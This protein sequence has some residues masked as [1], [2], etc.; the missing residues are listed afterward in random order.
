[1]LPSFGRFLPRLAAV[2]LWGC[3]G[4]FNRRASAT[5][6]RK[7]SQEIEGRRAKE[8]FSSGRALQSVP[9]SIRAFVF[10]DLQGGLTAPLLSNLVWSK[11]VPDAK[12]QRKIGG[13]DKQEGAS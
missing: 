1:V 2:I 11:Q 8:K 3:G 13:G 6:E 10:N 9:H 4:I 7:E 5:I 12:T